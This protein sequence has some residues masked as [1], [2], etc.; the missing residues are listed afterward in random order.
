MTKTYELYHC[1]YKGEV[2]YV[3]QGLK[4]R[5]KH[6]NSGS[7]HVYEL[8]K[9]HFTEGSDVLYTKVLK[10]GKSK[11]DMLDLEKEHISLIRPRFNSV[12]I[13]SPC[14]KISLMNNSK[15]VKKALLEYPNTLGSRVLFGAAVDKYKELCLEFLDFYSIQ[16]IL[17]KEIKFYSKDVFNKYGN[18]KLSLLVR[19]IRYEE[20][21]ANYHY[22][23]YEA[24]KDLHKIDL[25]E[26]VCNT[27]DGNLV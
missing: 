1:E 2:V 4:G 8:N 20:P 19:N 3:G 22:I 21:R 6:C 23:F 25:K 17:N 27:R 26:C 5:H 7:S 16:D 10:V 14:D 15:T 11:K 24:L 12:F 9:I 18:K 13:R